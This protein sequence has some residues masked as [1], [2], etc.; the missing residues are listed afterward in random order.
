VPSVA[1]ELYAYLLPLLKRAKE[2]DSPSA[3]LARLR[4]RQETLTH[5]LKPTLT[6]GFQARFEVERTELAPHFVSWELRPKKFTAERTLIHVHGG[7][8]ISP[9]DPAHLRWVCQLAEQV[10][11]RVILPDYPLAP[12]HT[13]RNAHETLV[14][15]ISKECGSAQQVVLSGDS[16]GAGLALACAMTV[17]DRA[18]TSGRQPNKLV[19]L[20]PWV[21]LSTSTP[22]TIDAA[23]RDPWLKLSKVRYYATLWAGS[24][25]AAEIARYE[26]SPA[27][28]NL[29][30]LPPA[31]LIYG[32]RDV[33]AP[34]AQLLHRRA[35]AAEW[36]VTAYEAEGLIHNYM[37]FPALP[38][39]SWANQVVARFVGS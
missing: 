30:G 5:K 27:L 35:M 13:W 22:E 4:A 28:G 36:Q 11:A 32:T 21:D 1:H 38:E 20:S 15:L 16:A 39:A 29:A 7:S 18:K 17:R 19:L 26:V 33:L 37:F 23:Q 31:L 34:G 10:S 14:E 24:G 8:F 9:I 12:R 3:E 6:P 25:E 2:L